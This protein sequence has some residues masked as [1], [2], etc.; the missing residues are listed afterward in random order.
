MK[1]FR[2]EVGNFD[3]VQRAGQGDSSQLILRKLRARLFCPWC[4][5][6]GY[7]HCASWEWAWAAVKRH[8]VLHA[9][10]IQGETLGDAAHSMLLAMLPDEDEGQQFRHYRISELP[11]GPSPITFM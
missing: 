5:G 9:D 2:I 10:E 6:D 3:I 8:L 11:A 4:S 7:T 1:R